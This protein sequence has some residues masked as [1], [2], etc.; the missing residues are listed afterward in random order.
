[1]G[2]KK[3]NLKDT[4]HA[5]KI[6]RKITVDFSLETTRARREWNNIFKVLK[7]QSC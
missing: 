5:E 3:K 2:N 7:E 6:R 4:L 1:M